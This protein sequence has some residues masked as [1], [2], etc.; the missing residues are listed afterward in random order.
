MSQHNLT[1]FLPRFQ[2]LHFVR[3][4]DT[5]SNSSN[6]FF[7][8][9]RI[10]FNPFHEKPKWSHP[11]C[12][13]LWNSAHSDYF[14]ECL[15]VQTERATTH[16]TERGRNSTKAPLL[17][18]NGF[19]FEITVQFLSHWL[20]WPIKPE[21]RERERDKREQQY[22][23]ALRSPWNVRGLAINSNL[24]QLG[25]GLLNW[26]GCNTQE[27]CELCCYFYVLLTPSAFFALGKSSTLFGFIYSCV[28][29]RT[30]LHN[31]F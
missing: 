15:Q 17:Y 1:F 3:S 18:Q 21:W 31:A 19:H 13:L 14:L 12:S 24:S 10:F 25:C 2:A 20:I 5:G 28:P 8:S 16:V 29:R 6:V 7:L 9:K 11:S 4:V 30:T 22:H 23:N 26:L 27:G